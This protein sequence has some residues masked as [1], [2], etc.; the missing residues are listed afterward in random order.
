M[1]HSLLCTYVQPPIALGEPSPTALLRPTR[2]LTLK[3]SRHLRLFVQ[4]D[5]HYT[6]LIQRQQHSHNTKIVTKALHFLSTE[7]TVAL[8]R[9]MVSLWTWH[10]SWTWL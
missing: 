8:K 9:K 6:V 4:N 2:A 3:V 10:S 1:I 7:F 5:D